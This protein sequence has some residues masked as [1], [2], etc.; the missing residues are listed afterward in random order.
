[1]KRF[2]TVVMLAM[3]LASCDKDKFE[4]NTGDEQEFGTLSF[5][6]L[7]IGVN[8][9]VEYLGTRAATEA[10]GSYKVIITHSDGTVYFDKT[11]EEAKNSDG[12]SLPA[13]KDGESYTLVARTTSA[14]VPAAA[15]DTPV[16]G[17]TVEGI[18]IAAGNE[19]VL[20][21][22]VC[23]LLQ[24]KVTVDYND[25]FKAM[26]RGNCTTTVTYRSEER[27]VGKECSVRCRSRWSPYH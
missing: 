26:V 8:E 1:M 16:Y 12:I 14:E 2:F 9:E 22:I 7:S 6:D 15:W 24:H 10:D 27:R 5:A 18:T 11:Y 13:T 3:A 4:Y 20:S 17:A 25:D 21:D 23:T 19:T